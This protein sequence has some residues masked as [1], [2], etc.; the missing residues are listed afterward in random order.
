M[1]ALF[2]GLPGME[3]HYRNDETVARIAL[4]LYEKYQPRLCAAYL[5]ELDHLKH[6]RWLKDME[7]PDTPVKRYYGYMDQVLGRFIAGMDPKTVLVV[8]SD[9]G[10]ARAAHQDMGIIILY[11]AGIRPGS[12]IREASVRDVTPTILALLGLPVG[13]DMD[14]AVLTAGLAPGL[15][16]AR[17]VRFIG[18]YDDIYLPAAPADAMNVTRDLHDKLR[19]MGYIE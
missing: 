3:K 16:E 4:Y 14:G 2:G 12:A 15:L 17:P 13:R 8:V 6:I 7:A 1:A 10:F 11:G 9:H 5:W 19:S 18:T